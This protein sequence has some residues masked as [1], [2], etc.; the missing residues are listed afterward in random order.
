V[1]APSAARLELGGASSEG[2][3]R[4][5]WFC[6]GDVRAEVARVSPAKEGG[7]PGVPTSSEWE[8]VTL[9]GGPGAFFVEH[10]HWVDIHVVGDSSTS[11][12]W[13]RSADGLA[14]APC[15]APDDPGPKLSRV[16]SPG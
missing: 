14:W 2:S 6:L 7:G 16:V 4:A 5:V 12:G 1:T 9:Y 11:W 8:E 13:Q 15:A 10:R 3:E